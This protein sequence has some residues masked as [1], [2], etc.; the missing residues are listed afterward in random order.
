MTCSYSNDLKN[1]GRGLAHTASAVRTESVCNSPNTRP[2]SLT[3]RCGI[4]SR[5]KTKTKKPLAQGAVQSGEVKVWGLCVGKLAKWIM[6]EE[7]REMANAIKQEIEDTVRRP[8]GQRV[9]YCTESEG[10]N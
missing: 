1:F 9:K 7:V 5:N 10:E 3:L 4:V 2:T 6:A 8:G